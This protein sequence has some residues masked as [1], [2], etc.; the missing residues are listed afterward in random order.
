M[1]EFSVK[2][3]TKDVLAV[4]EKLGKIVERFDGGKPGELDCVVRVEDKLVDDFTDACDDLN[5]RHEML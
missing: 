3:W 5:I 2:G 1:I 4:T